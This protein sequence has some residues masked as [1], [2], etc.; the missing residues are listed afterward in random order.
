MNAIMGQG[1]IISLTVIILSRRQRYYVENGE[2]KA[3]ID[4][5]SVVSNLAEMLLNIQ[6]ISYDDINK[7]SGI[8]TGSVLI[9]NCFI[10]S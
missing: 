8:H 9:E 7:N 10:N 3:S 4:N 1:V 6:N 5:F 2:I